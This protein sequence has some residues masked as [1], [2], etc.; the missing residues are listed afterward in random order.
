MTRK[1]IL[2]ALAAASLGAA[3]VP[4]AASA[5]WH[6]RHWGWGWG[7][8]PTYIANPDCFYVKKPVQFADGSW[9]IRR[10][11]VCN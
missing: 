9:H 5:H 8:G 4:T 6:H 2:A 3:L 7:F 10:V 11:W 1:L